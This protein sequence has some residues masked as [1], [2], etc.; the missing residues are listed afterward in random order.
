MCETLQLCI[1]LWIISAFFTFNGLTINVLCLPDGTNR[2]RLLSPICTN[3]RVFSF[4]I[5]NKVCY[6]D[7]WIMDHT[8]RG[9]DCFADRFRQKLW[10]AVP[11]NQTCTHGEHTADCWKC[12]WVHISFASQIMF[13]WSLVSDHS[14]KKWAPRLENCVSGK[15]LD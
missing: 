4:V 11:V 10:I 3:I 1:N 13:W 14:H 8:H 12:M 6:F 5:S 7:M 15:H 2:D 9:K